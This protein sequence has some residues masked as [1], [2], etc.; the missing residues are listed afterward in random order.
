MTRLVKAVVKGFKGLGNG[1]S[2]EFKG[3]TVIV[4][5]SGSGKT[6]LME[7]LAF[8][9]GPFSVKVVAEVVMVARNLSYRTPAGEPIYAVSWAYKASWRPAEQR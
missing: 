9:R 8:S 2:V 6:S 5:R 7:A 3:N 4:G 1:L